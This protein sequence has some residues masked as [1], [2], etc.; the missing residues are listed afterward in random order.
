[1]VNTLERT[2][3]YGNGIGLVLQDWCDNQWNPKGVELFI[4]NMG[5]SVHVH[6][7]VQTPGA[8]L[9][10]ISQSSTPGPTCTKLP[11]V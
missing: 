4:D 9:S 7:H 8:T 2:L 1:M 11:K 6:V 10:D 3:D 5:N